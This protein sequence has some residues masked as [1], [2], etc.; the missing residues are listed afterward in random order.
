VLL[1]RFRTFVTM[2]QLVS[3]PFRLAKTTATYWSG[4]LHYLAGSGRK[5]SYDLIFQ[6]PGPQD[7]PSRSQ[8]SSNTT[9]SSSLAPLRPLP[10]D[11]SE[12]RLFKQHARIHLYSLA[13]NFYLYHLP[14]YR[15]ASYRDDLVDNLR[16]VA[17][18]GTGIA[19]SWVARNRWVAGAFLMVGYP[20]VSLVSALHRCLRSGFA[21]SV[22]D[23]YE[24]RLLA[25][26]DWFR[27]VNV[28]LRYP[29]REK[30]NS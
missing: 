26:D 15:K 6:D 3:L 7:D 10:T 4:L 22:A 30:R 13:A 27:C 28:P 12:R 14:H 25:P 24:T 21:A 23:E 5:S 19:L 2:G 8:S 18:P 1:L 9:S 20:A 16:N 17:I 29:V 11:T